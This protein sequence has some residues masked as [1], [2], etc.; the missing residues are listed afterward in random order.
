MDYEKTWAKWEGW[1][2]ACSLIGITFFGV[3][4]S[5]LLAPDFTAEHGLLVM[6]ASLIPAAMIPLALDRKF[7]KSLKENSAIAQPPLGEVSQQDENPQNASEGSNMSVVF[8]KCP[9]C[10][11]SDALVC[12]N[13]GKFENI[14]LI[15]AENGQAYALCGC[16]QKLGW[17]TCSCGTTVHSKFFYEDKGRGGELLLK[18]DQIHSAISA[19]REYSK[20]SFWVHYLIW[21]GVLVVL[22]LIVVNA[23]DS[24]TPKYNDN[25][26]IG[27]VANKA[28][29]DEIVSSG[30]TLLVFSCLISFVTAGITYAIHKA[31]KAPK[32]VS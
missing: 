29:N 12:G 22:S 19:N 17:Q 3:F 20:I 11:K 18:K 21:A 14:E 16:G 23:W 26:A 10:E 9:K 4:I 30:A 28:R 8:W 13:C 1:V 31:I 25:Y 24:G 2:W 15:K 27:K 7:G 5:L 32:G 6:M